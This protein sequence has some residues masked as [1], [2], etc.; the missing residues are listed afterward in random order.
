M[1]MYTVPPIGAIPQG[2]TVV[3]W[4][5]SGEP[6]FNSPDALCLKVQNGVSLLCRGMALGAAPVNRIIFRLPYQNW[7]YLMST[8][9]LT[10]EK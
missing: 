8:G 9:G 6:F 1:G 5:A 3:V 7:A 10:F 4:R 2:G